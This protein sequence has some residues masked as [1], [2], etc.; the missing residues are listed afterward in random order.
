M[1][2][3]TRIKQVADE[4]HGIF[5]I[6]V[7]FDSGFFLHQF[8]GRRKARVLVPNGDATIRMIGSSNAAQTAISGTR[9]PADRGLTR[10]AWSVMPVSSFARGRKCYDGVP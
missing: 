6:G 8:V 2:L 3:D 10:S 9:T 5:V 7:G 1:V 4:H